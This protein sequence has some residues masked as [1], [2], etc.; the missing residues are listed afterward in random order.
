MDSTTIRT[1]LVCGDEA[2]RSTVLELVHRPERGLALAFDSGSSFT[3]LADQRLRELRAAEP[4]LVVLDL[5][6]DPVLGIKFA[7]YLCDQSPSRRILATGPMLPSEQLLSALRA[8]IS[9]YL[10]KPVTPEAL[11]TAVDALARK[12]RWSP[13]AS[14][15]QPGRLLAVFSGK[16]GSG[17]TTVATNLAIYL[18]QLTGKRA[19]LV[20]LDLELGEIALQLNVEPRFNFIDMVRNFHRMDAELLTSFIEHHPSG[21]HLLSAP[22]HPQ[23]TEVVT[24]AQIA[25]ILRFLK[26]H[27]DYVIVDTSKSFSPPTLATFEQADEI[28]LVTSVDL[29]SLRNIARCLPL[30]RQMVAPTEER[31]RLVLNRYH[32]GTVIRL[33]DVERSLGLPVFRT[34]GNDY[35]AVMRSINTGTPIILDQESRFARDV[36]ALGAEI[37]G[38]KVNPEDASASLSRSLVEPL[39]RMW[40]RAVLREPEVGG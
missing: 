29:P 2:F 33:E 22:Y 12:L 6:P 4:E 18:H 8:G 27:Y 3:H 25:K 7:Q 19:L 31:L 21:V 38:L 14:R 9:E 11:G 16:G 30:L 24:D 17:S 32:G 5:E 37:A 23:K 28:F 13:T 10:P 34:I 39:T 36:R 40:R 20:D 35:E 1:A 26:Q 15:T